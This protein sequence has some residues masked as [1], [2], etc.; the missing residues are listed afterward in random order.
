[1]MNGIG[2]N[3][4]HICKNLSSPSRRASITSSV[5]RFVKT[6]PGKGGMFTLEAS[7]SRTSRNHSKSLYLLRTVEVFNLKAGIFVCILKENELKNKKNKQKQELLSTKLYYIL[8]SFCEAF[9]TCLNLILAQ[10]TNG[11]IAL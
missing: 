3:E 2:N 5:K 8:K 10:T 4:T 7:R 1:M 9:R 11:R 6:F